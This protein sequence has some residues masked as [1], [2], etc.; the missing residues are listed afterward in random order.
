MTRDSSHFKKLH[1]DHADPVS[2]EINSSA[3]RVS[4]DKNSSAVPVSVDT[5]SSAS[6]QAEN[7]PKEVCSCVQ[8]SQ[9]TD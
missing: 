1:Q 3:D 7:P 8:T 5:S 6:A 9:E 2:V 4:V